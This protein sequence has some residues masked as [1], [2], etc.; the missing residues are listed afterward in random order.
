[1]VPKQELLWL[2]FEQKIS[3]KLQAATIGTKLRIES[4]GLNAFIIFFTREITFRERRNGH[5]E[6]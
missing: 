2:S 3:R 1:M 6:C 4:H 5:T